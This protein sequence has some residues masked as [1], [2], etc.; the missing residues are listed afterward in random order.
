LK[1]KSIIVIGSIV[2]VVLLI[3][4]LPTKPSDVSPEMGDFVDVREETKVELGMKTEDSPQIGD[5]TE[6]SETNFYIDENGTKHYVI[7]AEDS[8]ILGD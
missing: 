1:I 6:I 2:A 7:E 4:L 3:T 8:P 5:S